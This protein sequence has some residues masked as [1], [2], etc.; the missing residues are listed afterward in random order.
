VAKVE[1]DRKLKDE[2]LKKFK[3][4]S[5]KIFNLLKSLEN[6]PR[7]G[8]LLCVINNLAIKELRYKSFRFYFLVDS[9]KIKFLGVEELKDLMIKFVRMSD[10][11]SQQKVINEIKDLLRKI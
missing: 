9:F 11:N 3:K 6:L 7:K 2:I 8:K 1:I 10:K 4:D 5:E